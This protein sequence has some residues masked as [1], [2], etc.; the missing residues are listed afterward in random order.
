MKVIYQKSVEE[1]FIDLGQ[2]PRADQVDYVEITPY[3]HSV[4]KAMVGTSENHTV[5]S[6]RGFEVRV[7]K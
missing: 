3:E 6:Y 1:K 2:S 7:V 5:F 4:I